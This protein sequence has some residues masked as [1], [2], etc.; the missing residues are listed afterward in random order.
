MVVQVRSE[1]LSGAEE[2]GLREQDSLGDALERLRRSPMK[3]TMELVSHRAWTSEEL[4]LVPLLLETAD[5][6]E[7]Q[8]VVNAP[9][10]SLGTQ[11]DGLRLHRRISVTNRKLPQV[12][13]LLCSPSV[14]AASM[15]EVMAFRNDPER[16]VGFLCSGDL[17]SARDLFRW[18]L[19]AEDSLYSQ[20][21]V[22]P[23]Q[24]LVP[25]ILARV[26][27]D[28]MAKILDGIGAPYV[29]RVLCDDYTRIS[30]SVLG[31]VVGAMTRQCACK[32]I[33]NMLCG[34][35]RP[36]RLA[37]VLQ[38][39]GD[40]AGRQLLAAMSCEDL[41]RLVDA[42]ETRAD[43]VWVLE[44]LGAARRQQLV[45]ECEK[46]ESPEVFHGRVKA[47]AALERGVKHV[48]PRN[49]GWCPTGASETVRT[50]QGC[51]QV[52]KVDAGTW[53]HIDE[54]L[55]GLY[56]PKSVSIDVLSIDTKK[57]RLRAVSANRSVRPTMKECEDLFPVGES[58]NEETFRRAG[59]FR[60]RE[61][62]RL[63]GAVAAINGNFYFDFGHYENARVLGL[64]CHAVPDLR[65]G[66]PVGWYVE[67]G[68]EFTPPVLNRCAVVMAK[69]GPW[70][71]RVK[72]TALL[73]G[74]Q[75]LQ[76][77]LENEEG[78]PDQLVL[79]TSVFG[80][81]TAQVSG[82]VDISIVGLQVVESLAGGGATIPYTG[83]VLS[84]PESH[85][86]LEYLAVGAMLKVE[87]D[88][89]R[90]VGEV[91]CAMA[92]G[93]QL[94]K[95]G[96]INIDFVGEEFGTKDS[97]VM[98]FF[99]PRLID[100]YEAARSFLA[101][102]RSGRLLLGVVSGRALGT[103]NSTL[104]AGMTFGELAQLA[105]DLGAY[106]AINLDGGGSSS[107]I[108]SQQQQLQLLNVPTGGSDVAPGGER[109]IANGLV[110]EP[111]VSTLSA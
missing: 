111:K 89:P 53:Y 11:L 86:C 45:E 49:P 110:L 102:T 13:E 30:A 103:G 46:T 38:Q 50:A 34:A 2:R 77:D 47:L 95:D 79:Y 85:S 19:N 43:A 39:A 7:V 15:T 60:L 25:A 41:V 83:L 74:E 87:N 101:I 90:E 8:L 88:L 56:G 57:Y 52:K 23:Y 64:N 78:R 21:L 44:N 33:E 22:K 3:E 76:W 54:V 51:R 75:R 73:L 5:R 72:M 105:S 1:E 108:A 16:V 59:L 71:G 40:I 58:P 4:A 66:D 29:A 17:A 6:L 92:C 96:E 10:E 36:S 91:E 62:A 24:D 67:D 84:V 18:I 42:A 106:Q 26:P 99:L 48:D 70:I 104:T 69:G 97:A 94:I 37:A 68:H 31:A 27:S 107:L 100:R 9:D 61:R 81:K 55:H 63:E 98:S 32:V 12:D 65:F 109:F 82:R 14:D 28:R 80:E 35:D 93:P 20:N